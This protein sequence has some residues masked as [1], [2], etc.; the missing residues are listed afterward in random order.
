MNITP[1]NLE[2]DKYRARKLCARDVYL[3]YFAVM[4]SID[5]IHQTRHDRWPSPN[6]TIEE[7]LIDLGWHQREFEHGSSFAFTMMNKDESECLGCIYFYPEN[8]SD[9]NY[10]VEVSWW[11]TQK[12]YDEGMY[13]EVSWDIREWVE[14]DW[15]YKKV[16]FSNKQ[17][18]EG[19]DKEFV[20]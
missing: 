5:I 20:R 13:D 6:L 1:T 10:E 2:K 18:P 15:P 9:S 12:F 16:F 17:L 7:D 19:F 3:D 4:S 14:K 11:I 8:E